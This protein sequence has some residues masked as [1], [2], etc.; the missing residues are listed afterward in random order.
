MEIE[1]LTVPYENGQVFRFHKDQ[2]FDEV[3]YCPEQNQLCKV[4][5]TFGQPS[6]QFGG[7]PG[8]YKVQMLDMPGKPIKMA[9]HFELLAI[10]PHEIVRMRNRAKEN[11]TSI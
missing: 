7:H 8:F 4:I 11:S 9:K 1:Q 3:G 2:S 5:G 10:D 6:Y